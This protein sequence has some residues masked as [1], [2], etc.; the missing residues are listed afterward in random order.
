ME[1]KR[2]LCWLQ[3]LGYRFD[4]KTEAELRCQAIA[5]TLDYMV[6]CVQ[7]PNKA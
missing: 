1:L 5:A 7:T 6:R 2:T 4:G 3:S